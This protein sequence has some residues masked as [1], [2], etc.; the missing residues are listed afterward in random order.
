MMAHDDHYD[1]AV[2]RFR[3]D[4]RIYLDIVWEFEGQPISAYIVGLVEA[5]PFKIRLILEIAP[6]AYTAGRGVQPSQF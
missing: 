1:A 3:A 6:H 5:S 2:S 4:Y